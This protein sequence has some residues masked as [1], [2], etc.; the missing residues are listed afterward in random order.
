EPPYRTRLAALGEAGE[1]SPRYLGLKSPKKLSKNPPPER[2]GAAASIPA[3]GS[4]VLGSGRTGIA[5][6]AASMKRRQVC[7]G[8]ELPV[9]LFIGAL[10]SLP[11]HTPATRSAV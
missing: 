9:T 2:G 10:S 6:V 1:G 11:S 7:A 4:G 5:W 3:G 8:S